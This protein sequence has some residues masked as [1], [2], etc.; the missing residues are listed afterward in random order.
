MT[1]ALSFYRGL[2]VGVPMGLAVWGGLLG[3]IYI[4]VMR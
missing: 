4:V 2:L 3:G 1:D